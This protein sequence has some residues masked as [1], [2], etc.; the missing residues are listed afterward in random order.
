MHY[1]SIYQSLQ[2]ELG[3]AIVAPEDFA[4]CH[5]S[6]NQPLAVVTPSSE[7]EAIATVRWAAANH[8]VVVPAGGATLLNVD[9]SAND[10]CWLLLSSRSLRAV[11]EYSPNDMVITAAA[12]VTLSQLHKTLNVSR[13]WLPFDPPAP[14]RA[15]LGGIVAANT[16]GAYRAAYGAPRDRLLGLRVLTADGLVIKTGGK[17]VKNVAGYDLCKL[18]TGSWGELGFILE[19]TFK[20]Q[21]LPACDLRLCRLFSDL[22]AARLRP[23]ELKTALDVLL[24][25]QSLRFDPAFAVLVADRTV[26][27]L[28][29]LHGNEPKVEWQRNQLQAIVPSWE[30]ADAQDSDFSL[31]QDSR[32]PPPAGFAIE[33]LTLPSRVPELSLRLNELQ[34]ILLTAN[35]TAGR[36]TAQ[37][38]HLDARNEVW[39]LCKSLYPTGISCIFYGVPELSRSRL[40]ASMLGMGD[41]VVHALNVRIKRALDPANLFSMGEWVDNGVESAQAM[42][43]E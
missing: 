18:F 40:P 32:I 1:P 6:Q 10:K 5:A 22:N 33:F 19:T 28:I 15:T 9:P 3:S 2:A 20:V 39:N 43:S 13:Q 38:S 31:A 21:P 17:V 37:W 4:F 35:L 25:L 8:L 11:T 41:S 24:D 23:D 27:L 42:H 14:G 7:E 26:R 16:T 36:I 29:A 30:E 12:G 34:P